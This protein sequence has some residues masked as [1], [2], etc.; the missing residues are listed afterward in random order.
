MKTTFCIFAGFAALFF[1]SS[2]PS[3]AQADL[4]PTNLTLW[5]KADDG[6]SIVDGTAT[7]ADK[8]GNGNNVTQAG[9]DRHPAKVDNQIGP[10][11]NLPVIRFDGDDWLGRSDDNVIGKTDTAHTVF[12]VA[13]LADITANRTVFDVT[14]SGG[15]TSVL[16]RTIFLPGVG[17]K[18]F[19]FSVRDDSYNK[20]YVFD[21]TSRRTLPDFT[22]VTSERNGSSLE[23]WLDGYSSGSDST[24]TLG[25]MDSG[26]YYTTVGAVRNS[27]NT[28]G[29]GHMNGDIAEI[30]VYDRVLN[31]TEFEQVGY[32]LEQK[33]GLETACVPEPSTLVLLGVGALALLLAIYRRR[34]K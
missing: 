29:S 26:G 7:W 2:L 31:S 22:I 25:A 12:A 34:K 9:S 30:I 20:N 14:E 32:Y 19:E 33:Y 27:G 3:L 8:S 10:T 5:L 28:L 18:V 1:V 4:I 13:M 16:H 21:T 15:V 24:N 6:F 17:S 23:M 11:N